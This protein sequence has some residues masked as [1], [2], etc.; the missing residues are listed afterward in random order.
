VHLAVDFFSGND[1]PL[2][3]GGQSFISKAHK[4]LLNKNKKRQ[5][6]SMNRIA[7]TVGSYSIPLH[8]SDLRFPSVMGRLL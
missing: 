8:R 4:I 2:Q 3:S 6:D 7:Q 1:V 5:P